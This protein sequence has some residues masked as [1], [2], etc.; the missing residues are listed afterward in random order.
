MPLLLPVKELENQGTRTK[1]E[2][3]L[4]NVKQ[5][6]G[7]WRGRGWS[8]ASTLWNF[9][10]WIEPVGALKFRFAGNEEDEKGEAPLGIGKRE[11]REQ[12]I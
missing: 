10:E 7:S 9:L 12:L 1:D 3:S 5:L 4:E 11:Q 6:N 2:Q 8:P